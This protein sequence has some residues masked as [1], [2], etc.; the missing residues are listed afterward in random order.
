[1]NWKY[2]KPLIWIVICT[3][4][5]TLLTYIVEYLLSTIK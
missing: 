2:L 5:I 3:I 4:S 1:M